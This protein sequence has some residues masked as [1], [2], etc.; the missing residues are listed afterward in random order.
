[1]EQTN[2]FRKINEKQFNY[3]NLGCIS[4]CVIVTL[5]PILPIHLSLLYFIYRTLGGF[6][7]YVIQIITSF[8]TS[9][10]ST[11]KIIKLLNVRWRRIYDRVYVTIKC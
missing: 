4:S 1:M 6:R 8:Q 11:M 9:L 5:S 3:L 2:S 7:G 10:I